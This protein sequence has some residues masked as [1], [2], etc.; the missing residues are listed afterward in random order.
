MGSSYSY[1]EAE[2]F[3]WNYH[4]M[5][6][7]EDIR[8]TNL[9][10]ID[11]YFPDE[12]DIYMG[13]LDVNVGGLRYQDFFITDTN[14]AHFIELS[15]KSSNIP[16]AYCT[17]RV[18]FNTLP[19]EEYNIFKT[20]KMTPMIK[21]RMTQIMGMCNYSLCLRNSEHVA[22]YIFSGTWASFQMEEGGVLSP[23]FKDKMTK[24]QQKHI[25]IFPSSISPK[26]V[27]GS[28]CR[29]LYS[30]IDKQYTPTGFHYFSKANGGSYN[31]LVV[32]P[33]GA[34]KSRLINVLFNSQICDSLVS[35]QSVTRDV[36]FIEGNAEIVDLQTLK[37]DEKKIV[38]ADTVG[39]CDTEWSDDKIFEL[40]KGRVSRYFNSINAVFIVFRADRLLKEHVKNITM[41]MDWLQYE[42]YHL[43]FMFVGTFAENLNDEEKEKLKVQ[44]RSILKLKDT[45]IPES[46]YESLV[47]VGFPPEEHLNEAGKNQVKAS[48]ELL[49]PLMRL[50]EN[51]HQLI[52]YK[53]HVKKANA[54]GSYI[55]LPKLSSSCTIL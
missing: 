35:H 30:M 29:R 3:T 47:Y 17:K 27:S 51:G 13:K 16:T 25:N 44:A 38:V 21:E 15:G 4:C 22:N 8:I 20:T 48:W 46:S 28:N 49:Q 37:K 53:A 23:F 6:F 14:R 5:L 24:E 9:N 11:M 40:L 55:K 34:G 12:S 39:L 50:N 33:T 31:I 19:Y 2:K 32:G 42:R 26:T 1:L 52:N 45:K 36:C 18:Q 41:V 7:D 10:L 54:W 43:N